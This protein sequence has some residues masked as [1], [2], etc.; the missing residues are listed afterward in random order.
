MS[1][2]ATPQTDIFMSNIE[3]DVE[4]E[5]HPINCFIC[6]DKRKS[7]N[8]TL[9]FLPENVIQNI[10]Y[11]TCCSSCKKT[12][13]MIEVAREEKKTKKRQ[14]K[15]QLYMKGHELEKERANIWENHHENNFTF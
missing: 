8:E 9:S 13:E 3:L 6:N 4:D 12:F 15:L 14:M 11:F 10:V 7:L 2:T 1:D 5:E